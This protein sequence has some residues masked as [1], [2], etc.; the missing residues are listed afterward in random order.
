MRPQ[1][2]GWA[3]AAIADRL[4]ARRLRPAWWHQTDPMLP[5]G[6]LDPSRS[7]VT[8]YDLIPL[9]EPAVWE[10]IRPHRRPLYRA[11]LRSLQ[12]AARVA[13]ISAATAHDLGDLLGIRADR[14]RVIPP[15]VEVPE[16][17]PTA[18]LDPTAP[19]LL[20]VGVPDPHKR[21]ELALLTLEALRRRRPGATLTFIGPAGPV[22]NHVADPRADRRNQGSVSR[23][24]RVSDAALTDLYR[25]SVLLAVSRVEGFGL[26]PVEAILA[27]GRVVAV[28]IPIYREVLGPAAT[29]AVDDD[30][31][32]LATAVELAL[33]SP[34][35]LDARHALAA[36]YAPERLREALAG[37]YEELDG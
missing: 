26:P 8:A 27:G 30:P 16:G 23:F 32:S 17:G 15:A 14:I 21:A 29:F 34:P 1:D 18:D 35:D 24:G 28:P 9:L 11:Y 3:V 25:S 5:W 33:Q 36:R 2:L 10:R 20:F 13:T 12:R 6:P 37:L 7:V 22:Q 4:V 31:D 19:N